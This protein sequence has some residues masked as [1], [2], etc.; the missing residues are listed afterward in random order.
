MP[1]IYVVDTSALLNLIL[2]PL[3]KK[4]LILWLMEFAGGNN[5]F[6]HPFVFNKEFKE[7]KLKVE[8]MEPIDGE[9]PRN[10][11]LNFEMKYSKKLNIINE[12]D[13]IINHLNNC[14]DTIKKYF[15]SML[16]WRDE[17]IDNIISKGPGEFYTTALAL[18]LNRKKR[19]MVIFLID[20]DKARRCYIDK[21]FISQNIGVCFS[22]PQLIVMLSN[23]LNL[24]KDK[25]LQSITT[26]GMNLMRFTNE[27]KTF[28]Y[29]FY[30][31]RATSENYLRNCCRYL[32]ENK[33]CIE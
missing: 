10:L 21:F 25:T 19:E 13:P 33:V 14:E 32:C 24:K 18:Y 23:I 4:P 9:D 28:E 17:D 7:K 5:I 20:D 29:P 30:R 12:D 8:R 3:D 2:C 22:V 11:V 26:Y 1:S 6:I 31:K 16:H 27:E 15:K